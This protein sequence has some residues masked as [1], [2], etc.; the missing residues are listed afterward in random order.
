[1]LHKNLHSSGNA[2]LAFQLP[3]QESQVT[4]TL[5]MLRST[6]FLLKKQKAYWSVSLII[7]KSTLPFIFRVI[8][9]WDFG[10]YVMQKFPFSGSHVVLMISSICHRNSTQLATLQLNLPLFPCIKNH[11]SNVAAGIYTRNN[12]RYGI[13]Y[14]DN[15]ICM[16][17]N[18]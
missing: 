9:L 5:Q 6:C 4:K 18:S 8:K 10:C 1:M 14:G 12:G 13:A 3:Y 7:R 17:K 16:V 11:L 2:V 15:A